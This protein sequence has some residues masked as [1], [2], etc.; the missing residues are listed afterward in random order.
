M[1]LDPILNVCSNEIMFTFLNKYCLNQLIFLYYVC[2]K[3]C[4][5]FFCCPLVFILRPLEQVS[6]TLFA[7]VTSVCDTTNVDLYFSSR[8]LQTYKLYT[9]SFEESCICTILLFSRFKAFWPM[10]KRYNSRSKL[11]HVCASG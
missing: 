6:L 1:F 5:L 4:Q 3:F 2:F 9:T 11:C 7:V 8:M 10:Y